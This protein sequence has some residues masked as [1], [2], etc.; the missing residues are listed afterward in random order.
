[1]KCAIRKWKIEDAARLAELLNNKKIQNNLRDGLPYPYTTK[2]AEDYI[3]SM[4]TAEREKTFAF[5]ITADDEVVG[6]IGVFRCENIHSR[7]AEMGYYIGEPYWGMGLGTEAVKQICSYIFENTDIIRIFA[8]PF[9]YNK[10]SCRVLEKAGFAFE[11]ILKSNA[12]KNGTVI[13][14]RMYALVRK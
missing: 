3:T 2:D 8:E 6:S 1:M 14:M 7:T 10:A 12:V 4:L 5:A 9:A 11:G 13:D